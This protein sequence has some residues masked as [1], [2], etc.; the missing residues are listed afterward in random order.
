MKKALTITI[1]VIALLI[2]IPLLFLAFR[3]NLIHSREQEKA[4]FA[5]PTS[6]FIQWRGAEI[7][8]LDEGQGVPVVM[9]HGFGGNHRNF[10]KLKERMKDT[11]RV[12]RID[13]PGFGLS[14][15][16]RPDGDKTNY[17]TEYRDFMR[18]MVDT[19]HLDSVYVIG[20]SM[21]G[22]MSWNMA[23]DQPQKVKKLVLIGSAGYELDKVAKNAVAAGLLQSSIMRFIVGKGVPLATSISLAHRIYAD[24]AKINWKE[25]ENNNRFWNRNGNLKAAGMLIAS[26][27]FPDSTLITQ[28]RCPTLIIWGKN[29][30]I[31]PLRHAYKFQRDIQGSQLYL[32]DT[33]GHVPMI[34]RTDET[35]AAIQ[36]FFAE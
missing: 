18:F 26:R 35:A 12:I 13:L 33:C 19:L 11:Y 30:Q 21:G 36:R 2:A 9:L 14:D 23:V 32:L 24:T 3:P 15:L 10:E 20:N 4:W 1:V 8:Y 6:H 31:V 17:L 5:Q 16:P 25:I 7:H 22:M 28:V 29:D 27:Q 34:E